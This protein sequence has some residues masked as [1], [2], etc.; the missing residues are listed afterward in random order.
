M[1]HDIHPATERGAPAPTP[2][3]QH[4]GSETQESISRRDKRHGRLDDDRDNDRDGLQYDSFLR[5][6]RR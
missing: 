6:I 5:I 2:D 4:L 3:Q 1:N